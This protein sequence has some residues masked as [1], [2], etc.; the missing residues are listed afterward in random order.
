[1]TNHELIELLADFEVIYRG[2][3]WRRLNPKV[4]AE[5][6]RLAINALERPSIAVRASDPSTSRRAAANVAPRAGSQRHRLLA[7]Y[8]DHPDGL[9]DE[10]AGR[11]AGLARPGVCYWKRCSELR[12]G[13]FIEPLGFSRV[14][15]TGEA[16]QVCGIT[17]AGRMIVGEGKLAVAG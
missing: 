14:A 16:Q 7:V 4:T 10:E 3:D 2:N 17:N 9:T 15:S 12:E 13:V 1:M 6:F 11:L 5:A 8:A